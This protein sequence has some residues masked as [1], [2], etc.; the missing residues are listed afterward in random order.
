[1]PPDG[2]LL[3]PE[4]VVPERA[5]SSSVIETAMS[6]L[7]ML[8]LT[9]GGVERTEEDLR[10]LLADSGFRLLAISGTIP[11]TDFRVIEAGPAPV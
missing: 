2:M 5:G 9:T 4:P 8:L 10:R 3:L 11:D 7:N 6:D 1:M